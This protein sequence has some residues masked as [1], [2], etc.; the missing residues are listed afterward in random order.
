MRDEGQIMSVCP[1]QITSSFTSPE[2]RVNYT[3]LT[4][5][6]STSSDIWPL[7]LVYDFP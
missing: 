2:K 3:V 6:I 1:I 4:D 5:N 7:Q